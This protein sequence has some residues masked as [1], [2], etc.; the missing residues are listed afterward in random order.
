MVTREGVNGLISDGRQVGAVVAV[1]PRV[2]RPRP[3]EGPVE[4]FGVVDPLS[5]KS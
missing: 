3:A 4:A 2:W 1:Q 5:S